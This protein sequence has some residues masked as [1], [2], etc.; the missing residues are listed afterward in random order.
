MNAIQEAEA[1]FVAN[2]NHLESV[3]MP[4]LEEAAHRLAPEVRVEGPGSRNADFD[5][6]FRRLSYVKSGRKDAAQLIFSANK[7]GSENKI[8]VGEYVLGDGPFELF[9]RDQVTQEFVRTR[10]AKFIEKVEKQLT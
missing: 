10:V 5:G 7:G 2:G 8:V 1:Q 9:T 6:V 3:V 4:I